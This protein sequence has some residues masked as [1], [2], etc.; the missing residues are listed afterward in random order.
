MVKQKRQ[1]KKK[2]SPFIPSSPIIEKIIAAQNIDG[3][4]SE[5]TILKYLIK[6]EKPIEESLKAI[7]SR[8]S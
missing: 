8:L 4:W 6:D 7:K 5:I 2:K 3:S 1:K